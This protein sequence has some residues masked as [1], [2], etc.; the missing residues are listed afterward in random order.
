MTVNSDGSIVAWAFNM[1]ITE[2]DI[3]ANVTPFDRR[4]NLLSAYGAGSCNCD[5]FHLK[6]TLYVERG[7]GYELL[8]PAEVTYRSAN[9]LENWTVAQVSAVP[10]PPVYTMMIGGLA[11]IGWTAG[12]RRSAK[13]EPTMLSA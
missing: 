7:Y 5:V 6:N 13:N 9:A 3:P 10:Q 2:M 1:L 4:V 12:R 8:G 11:L